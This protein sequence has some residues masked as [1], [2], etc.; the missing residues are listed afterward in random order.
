MHQN[1]LVNENLESGTAIEF[2]F[3]VGFVQ[4][5]SEWLKNVIMPLMTKE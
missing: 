2:G 3:C 5:L 1:G 4:P